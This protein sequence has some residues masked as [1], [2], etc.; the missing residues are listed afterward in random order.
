MR[1]HPTCAKCGG[2]MTPQNA[3]VHPE[4]FLHDACL[5]EELRPAAPAL[6][7]QTEYQ[8][9]FIA[10]LRTYARWRDGV[11]Y[12]GSCGMTLEQAIDRFLAEEASS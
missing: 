3:R 12:V 6:A 11:Q 4:Y 2:V 10:A 1:D 5:P 9:G 7:P 8:R